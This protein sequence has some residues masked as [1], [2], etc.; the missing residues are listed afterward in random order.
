L[1]GTLALVWEAPAEQVHDELER[2][3]R[4]AHRAAGERRPGRPEPVADAYGDD[5][6]A[7]DEA[8]VVSLDGWKRRR[9]GR[10]RRCRGDA[11]GRRGPA[12]G[13]GRAA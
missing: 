2:E 4:R 8:R 3:R 12:R 6:E 1:I 10:R 7:D 11:R 9:R 5:D 13:R